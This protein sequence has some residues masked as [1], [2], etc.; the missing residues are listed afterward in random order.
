M[1]FKVF[2]EVDRF[3]FQSIEKKDDTLPKPSANDDKPIKS[4]SVQWLMDTLAR[5]SI[6]N[7]VRA[8]H[9]FLDKVQWG[10]ED[11]AVRVKLT[12][13]III[14]VERLITDKE[15]Q[16]VW[17]LKTTF[18]PKIEDFA[19]KEELV[20]V[21][22]FDEVETIYYNELENTKE[23]YHLAN[24]VRR[25]S[26]R[27][28]G[29]APDLLMFGDI[30]EVKPNYFIISFSLRGVGVGKLAS[31]IP[32]VKQ[33][34][35]LTIEVEFKKERGLIHVIVSSVSVGGEGSTWS[36]DIPYLNA[37]FTPSQSKDEIIDNV[38]TIIKYF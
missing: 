9:K 34:P 17:I 21:D 10:N 14:F 15:G 6:G 32:R 5:K 24:L 27:I 16:P 8:T 37:L 22:V 30:K 33:T 36:Q 29:A 35:E 4:F 19:G 11:G 38:I 1:M 26:G 13:N 20:A 7:S 28:R 2:L 12:P 31:N 18:K 3:G 23:D 25:M